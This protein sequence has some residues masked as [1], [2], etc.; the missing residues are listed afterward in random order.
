[1]RRSSCEENDI[2]TKHFTGTNDMNLSQ[3]PRAY[4]IIYFVPSF[5][6]NTEVYNW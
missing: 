4:P 6:T 5:N 3:G 1:M 2:V